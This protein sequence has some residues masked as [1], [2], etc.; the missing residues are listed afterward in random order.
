MKTKCMKDL[1]IFSALTSAEREEVGKLAIK[2]IYKKN[3]FVFREGE[4]ADSIY[5]IKSGRVRVF[6]TSEDGKEL[7]LD[8]FKSE[9]I[10]G[11]SMFFEN[12]LHTM[13]ARALEDTFICCCTKELF[14]VLLQNPEASLTII[15]H[16]VQKANNYTEHL[17]RIAFMD[18]R[19]RIMDLLY[20]LAEKYGTPT[21]AGSTICID[22]THQDIGSLVNAS[23]VMVTNVLSELR[24]EK[25]VHINGHRITILNQTSAM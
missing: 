13:N 12:A 11:E 1:E 4:A 8:F 25:L 6:K 22:L 14:S 7:T 5:L 17:S 16:L 20:R 18:V 19:G 15:Q 23:R 10:L 24:K 2:K 21:P 3:E 9:D